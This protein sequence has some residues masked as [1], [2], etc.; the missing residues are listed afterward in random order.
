MIASLPAASPGRA[1][2]VSLTQ[3]A[4]TVHPPDFTGRHASWAASGSLQ[5]AQCHTRNYCSDCH[6]GADSRAFH[7]ANFVERHAAEVFGAGGNCRSCHSTETFCQSCHN[8][9]GLGSQGR[10]NA[11]FHTGQPLWVL[12]HGQAARMGM[13]SCASC[14]RQTDCMQCHSAAGGWG[15]NPHG[16]GFNASRMAARNQAA[17]RACHLNDPIGRD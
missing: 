5:C 14:H 10:M 7:P 2:G 6:A 9:A 13:E 4:A 12:S 17:C 3:A 1:P 16:P 11:A 8:A 15:V